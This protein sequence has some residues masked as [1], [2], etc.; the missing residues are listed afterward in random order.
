MVNVG[1]SGSGLRAPVARKRGRCHLLKNGDKSH[2]LEAAEGRSCS[3]EISHIASVSNTKV[4]MPLY[5]F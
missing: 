4:K 2:Y 1:K 3:P 5:C